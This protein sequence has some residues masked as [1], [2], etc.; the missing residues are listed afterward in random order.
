MN[1][2]TDEVVRLRESG[3]QS[4][5]SPANAHRCWPCE[6]CKHGLRLNTEPIVDSVPKSL[7]AAQISLRR[8]NTDMSEQKLNLLQL[9][10]GF[11]AEPCTSPPFMPHAA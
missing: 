11:V 4:R 10:A 8:P 6:Y 5:E 3:L 2:T 1:Y 9:A 7:L